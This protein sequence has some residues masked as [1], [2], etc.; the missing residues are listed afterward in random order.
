MTTAA[1]QELSKDK[2]KRVV[3]API[4]PINLIFLSVATLTMIIISTITTLYIGSQKVKASGNNAS[5]SKELLTS[6]IPANWKTY[7]NDEYGFSLMYPNSWTYALEGPNAAMIDLQNGKSISGTIQPTFNTIDFFDSYVNK[8]FSISIY[9]T[10]KSDLSPEQ[11]ENGY[12]YLYGPCDLR[13]GFY[14][15]NSD[16]INVNNIK[17]LRVVGTF[18]STEQGNNTACY[19][20][21]NIKG[22][23][24]VLNATPTSSNED[25][26][27]YNQILST[28]KFTK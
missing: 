3:V 1:K 5:L 28:L 22:N 26:S 9:S 14:P 24:I 25:F 4:F 6:S 2:E 7:I 15:T 16:T 8:E 11:F 21:K 17:V 20:V 10:H 23:L 19:Y 12:L 27:T 18:K 13:A